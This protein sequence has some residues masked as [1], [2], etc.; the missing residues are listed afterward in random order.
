[1]QIILFPFQSL[2]CLFQFAIKSFIAKVNL[3]KIFGPKQFG[4]GD[5][6]LKFSDESHFNL[7]CLKLQSAFAVLG[8]V[9]EPRSRKSLFDSQQFMREETGRV[10]HRLDAGRIDQT[11]P[12]VFERWKFFQFLVIRIYTQEKMG[13]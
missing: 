6:E 3:W 13:V 8:P 2:Q 4:G 12:F 10:K 7:D 5:G 11:S 1:M 9:S